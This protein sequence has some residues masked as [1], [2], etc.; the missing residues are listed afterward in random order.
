MTKFPGKWPRKAGER[1][2]VRGPVGATYTEEG[3]QRGPGTAG[4][5]H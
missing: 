3:G 4:V 1:G 2:S 5:S